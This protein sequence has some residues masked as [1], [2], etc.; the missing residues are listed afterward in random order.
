VSTKRAD[1]IP[2]QHADLK[3]AR[4]NHTGRVH[5]LPYVPDPGEDGYEPEELSFG[6]GLAQFMTQ[7]PIS[8]LCGT[9]LRL[10]PRFHDEHASYVGGDHFTDDDLCIACVMALGDQQWRAF[11]ADN[12]GSPDM[13]AAASLIWKR[14]V[15]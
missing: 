14:P 11:H 12:R 10:H 6:E 5:I 8:M 13:T 9:L 4:N 2:P 1:R 3:F 7:G 15:I